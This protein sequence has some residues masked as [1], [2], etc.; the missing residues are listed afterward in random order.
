M[1]KKE[2]LKDLITKMNVIDIH[3]NNEKSI[4]LIFEDD[5]KINLYSESCIKDRISKKRHPVPP[6]HFAAPPPVGLPPFAVVPFK[7]KKQFDF[8]CYYNNGGT[9]SEN[10]K[11]EYQ[12]WV[13][14]ELI[15]RSI[16]YEIIYTI[17][18]DILEYYNNAIIVNQDNMEISKKYINNQFGK[19]V[20]LDGPITIEKIL[21]DIGSTIRNIYEDEELV[22]YMNSITIKMFEYDTILARHYIE[23]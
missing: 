5:T 18:Q 8:C 17:F 22:R 16:E 12:L 7:I 10:V 14:L 21:F 6:P 2:R 20:C 4:S 13:N 9:I 19:Y 11:H 15:D 23:M 3:R 1:A